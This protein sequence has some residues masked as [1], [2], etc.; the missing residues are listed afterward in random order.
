MGSL[1]SSCVSCMRQLLLAR[2]Y[3]SVSLDRIHSCADSLPKKTVTEFG[4]AAPEETHKYNVSS[5]EIPVS[6]PSYNFTFP[7]IIGSSFCQ[8]LL[9]RTFFKILLLLLLS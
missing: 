3:V 1:P 5:L 2:N 9:F 8:F 6:N 7:L 4:E